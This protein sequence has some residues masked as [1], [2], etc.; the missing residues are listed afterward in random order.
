MGKPSKPPL[1]EKGKAKATEYGRQAL[2]KSKPAPGSGS[3]DLV[4]I[5]DKITVVFIEENGYIYDLMIT[6]DS[7]E[8]SSDTVLIKGDEKKKPTKGKKDA[9]G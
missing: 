2:S 7:N 5:G 6:A 1:S 8:N 9:W 4:F 3:D